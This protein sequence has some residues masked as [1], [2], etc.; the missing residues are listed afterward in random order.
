MK[1]KLLLSIISGLSIAT[2]LICLLLA[3]NSE[4]FSF[5]G[6][7]DNDYAITFNSSKNKFH[8]Y[9]GNTA[10][11]GTATIKTNLGNDI[12]FNYYQVKGIASTWHVLGSGG[13]FYNVDPIHGLESI[14]LSFKTSG[15]SYS[16]YYS[17]DDSFDQHVDYISS[18]ESNKLFDFDGY[19]PNYFKVVNTSGSNFNI[20]SIALRHSCLNNYPRLDL[21]S[22]NETMGTVSGGGVKV[23]GEIVTIF[24]TPKDDYKFIGWF[25]K[26]SILVSN[27]TSY[28]FIMG[29][30]DLEYTARFTYKTYNLVVQSESV[31]K[32]IV[33]DS[34]GSYRYSTEITISAEAN[35]G[36]SFSG[37]YEN[38][39]LV[40]SSNPYT[41]TMPRA[42]KICTAKFSTN[43]SF[44]IIIN[45]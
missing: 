31:E 40:S 20:S 21:F 34:S 6:Q 3:S 37:C 4:S 26:E 43:T 39:S 29:N 33:S 18:T 1:K 17:K 45:T 38:S 15:T 44:I 12:E 7:A 11:D 9:T 23:A 13:Y 28:S 16:I 32:G 41:F 19:L 22:E 35:S 25:D 24:A 14:D 36:Y 2:A 42:E 10:Y 8:S 27:N 30:E 5:L